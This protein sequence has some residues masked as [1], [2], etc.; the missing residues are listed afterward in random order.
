MAPYA[1]SN[2][3]QTDAVINPGNSGGP[4]V[5]LDGQVVG[6]N[7]AIF[8]RSGGYMGV[9]FAIP[10]NLLQAIADQLIDKGEVT[11]GFLGIVIQQLTPDLA[12]SLG[13]DVTEGILVAQVNEESPARKAGLRVGDVVVAYDGSPVTD[14]LPELKPYCG[15]PQD[16]RGDHRRANRKG[17]VRR[18]P[19]P[20]CR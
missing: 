7:T 5:N 10:S 18:R 9:G 6:M 8:S 17:A 20:G 14:I 19:D 4:L 2:Y 1:I 12:E 15:K 13:I 16:P 11:R 3:I